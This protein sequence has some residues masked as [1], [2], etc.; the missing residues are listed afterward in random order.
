MEEYSPDEMAAA[1]Q[2]HIANQ[3][4]FVN[5]NNTASFSIIELTN[6]K[7]LLYDHRTAHERLWHQ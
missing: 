2:A 1:Q 6:L 3:A 4:H 5:P 7:G